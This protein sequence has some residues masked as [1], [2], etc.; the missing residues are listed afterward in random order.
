MEREVKWVTSVNKLQE[1]GHDSPEVL[2]VAQVASGVEHDEF[3]L[4]GVFLNLHDR[5]LVPTPASVRVE[6]TGSNSWGQTRR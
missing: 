6:S 5:G 1:V 4:F 3:G 2:N